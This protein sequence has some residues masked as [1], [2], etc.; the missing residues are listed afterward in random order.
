MQTQK[1]ATMDMRKYMRREDLETSDLWC[2]LHQ[3]QGNDDC[4]AYHAAAL[5]PFW[6]QAEFVYYLHLEDSEATAS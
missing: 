5:S 1:P 6:P 3:R 4:K 2:T